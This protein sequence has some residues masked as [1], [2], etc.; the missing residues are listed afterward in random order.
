MK[1]KIWGS[2]LLVPI[3]GVFLLYLFIACAL[4]KFGSLK[5][6]YIDPKDVFNTRFYYA[7]YYSHFFG[8]LVLFVLS[9]VFLGWLIFK[10]ELLFSK[11]ITIVFLAMIVIYIVTMKIDVGNYLNWFFD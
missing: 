8:T 9:I 11:K 3:L 10:K 7:A 5:I 1:N 6:Y 2:L 4:N